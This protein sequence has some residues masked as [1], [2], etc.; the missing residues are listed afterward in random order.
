MKRHVDNYENYEEELQE[1]D[2]N[3]LYND[4][5]KD[6][7]PDLCSKFVSSKHYEPYD[8]TKNVLNNKSSQKEEQKQFFIPN[9]PPTFYYH[10]YIE[11][12][13]QKKNLPPI[14][15]MNMPNSNLYNL[16]DPP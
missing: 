11:S 14:R 10:A 15:K 16:R 1:F 2:I 12:I 13:K 9:F 7:L 5:D 4:E 8:M 6:L 3:L